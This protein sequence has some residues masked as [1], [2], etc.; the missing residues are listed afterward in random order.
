MTTLATLR[1]EPR[2]TRV[3]G[4]VGPSRKPKF[5]SRGVTVCDARKPVDAVLTSRDAHH[6]YSTIPTVV[7]PFFYLSN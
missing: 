1:V 7:T 6:D 4:R 5:K 3:V 2:L